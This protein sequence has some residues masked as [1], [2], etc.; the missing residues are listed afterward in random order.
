MAFAENLRRQR[1][2]RMFE[3]IRRGRFHQ[4]RKGSMGET[5]LTLF[6]D[7][8]HLHWYMTGR[9]IQFEIVQNSPAKHVGQENIQRDCRRMEL[10]RQTKRR[11]ASIRNDAFEALIAS[12]A[13]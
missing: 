13:Q 2:E 3:F 12:H 9:R 5:V 11:L 1:L 7:G 8:Q 6:L 4:I 10:S